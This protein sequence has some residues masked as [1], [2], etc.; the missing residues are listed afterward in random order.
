MSW[1]FQDVTFPLLRY[2]ADRGC[3]IHQP[4][5]LEVG[6]GT[7]HPA[8]FFRVLGPEPWRTAYVEP[9]RRPTDGRYGENPNR[10]QHYY[11]L[12]VILKPAPEDIQT[13][14]LQ[15]LTALGIR[16]ADHD[17]RFVEDEWESPTL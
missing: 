16:L 11:Q 13:L 17:I 6:A 9:S 12:Q 1:P 3:V 15:S 5:D 8:T 7:F 10:L 14:Y 2:W 4:Y